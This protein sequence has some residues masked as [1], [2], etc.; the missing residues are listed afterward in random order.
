MWLSQ[1]KL[2]ASMS[3]FEAQRFR[4]YPLEI[5]ASIFSRLAEVALYTAFWFIVSAYGAHGNITMKDI[6]AYYL[7]VTG[8]T[9]FF[10]AGFGVASMTIEHIKS[11]QLNQ[12]LIRPVNPIL[13]PWANRTGRNAFN[14]AFGL[15]EI[16]VGMIISGGIH[17]SAL[18]FLLPVLCNTLAI[19]AA[20]N[21]IIGA[22]G[23]YFTDARGLKNTSLH[24]ASFAR[25]EKMPL[26]LMPPGLSH[27]L[28]LTPFPASQYHLAI[29]LQGTRLP[30]WS[31]V[32]LGCA[33]SV[34]LIFIA[35]KF[36]QRG[37]RNY[38]AVGI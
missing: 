2:L 17:A 38:E 25:G 19:N 9:P 15:L 11:G 5:V 33:W 27:F 16:I 8:L 22:A 31:D 35:V 12:T 7:I 6:I 36:W 29:L 14:I 26:H 4:A 18:P 10:Y 32:W 23:F 21:I 28:L 37:L 3:W 34:A 13:Y 24:I 1:L 30:A 20:F